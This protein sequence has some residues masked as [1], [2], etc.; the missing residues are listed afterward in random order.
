MVVI[1]GRSNIVSAITGSMKTVI[2]DH[3]SLI[4]V[5]LLDAQFDRSKKVG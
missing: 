1:S 2:I 5:V 4:K 3:W